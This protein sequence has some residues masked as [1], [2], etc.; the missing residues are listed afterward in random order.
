MPLR[1]LT[2]EQH[3]AVVHEGNLL[4]TAC[5]GSGKT[6][7]LVSRIANLL[8]EK[9]INEGKRLIIAITYTNVAAETILER[10]DSYGVD[11]SNLW[12]GTIHSFCLEWVIKPYTGYCNR[13]STGFRI[14]DEYEQRK[15][16]AESKRPFD[17]GQYDDIPIQLNSRFEINAA[18]QTQLYNAASLYHHKLQENKWIDFDLILSITLNLLENDSDIGK[19]LGNLFH[20]IM[21]DEYQDTNHLQYEILTHI[22]SHQMTVAT[23]I[24]DVD[25]AIYTGLGAVVKN[26]AQ[27]ENELGLT[28]ITNKTLSGCYRSTQQIIDFYRNFQDNPINIHSLSTIPQAESGV[29]YDNNVHRDNLGTH[30]GAI[31]QQKINEG[32]SPNEIVVLAPQWTDVFRLGTLLR[33]AQ[34][35]LD[36]NAPSISPI[37]KSQDNPWINLI[38]LFFT[39]INSKNYSKRR[40]M[41]LFLKDGLNEMGFGFSTERDTIK[42]IL[43]SINQIEPDINGTI[44]NFI[45]SITT[46]FSEKVDLDLTVY[47][48]LYEAKEALKESTTNRINQYSLAN[49]ASSLS[50]YFSPN[51][52]IEVTSCHATKGEEYDVVIATGLLEG[53]LPH[54]ND[55]IDMPQAHTNYMARRLLYVI[56]SRARKYLFL[57]SEQGHTTRRGHALVPT[58]QL[59]SV[60]QP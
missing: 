35:N 44:E 37:P 52:G 30:I 28:P 50:G 56:S 49:D 34:P 16:I 38:R 2:V 1:G 7:T 6:K 36:F 12:V 51:G 59:I 11:S 9:E 58:P 47:N 48:L 24:G 31:I 8:S 18:P 17:I 42:L 15:L 27:I 45:D 43:K 29:S 3:D 41:A 14:I 54:W 19:R 53:K 20:S 55:I 33:Q 60:L 46:L 21:V 13:I 39:T 23:F 10:L 26:K 25:Q 57:I 40:R 4:L 32:I 22:L 5:P